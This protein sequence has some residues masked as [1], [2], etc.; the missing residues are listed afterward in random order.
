MLS[1]VLENL[2]LIL[3]SLLWTTCGHQTL[4]NKANAS[5]WQQLPII[6]LFSS[7]AQKWN[8]QEGEMGL[9]MA[10]VEV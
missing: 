8:P 2:I 7:T 4:Q 10:I 6:Q 1:P 9:E 3:Y 5:R